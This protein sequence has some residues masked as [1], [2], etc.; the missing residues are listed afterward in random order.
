MNQ[1]ISITETALQESA[2]KKSKLQSTTTITITYIKPLT[3]FIKPLSKTTS[4]K[5]F[6]AT[7]FTKS[8][9]TS[10]PTEL[11]TIAMSILSESVISTAETT[12]IDTD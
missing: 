5:Y 6:I 10:T 7:T 9:T 8:S 11:S 1:L 4:T 3:S 12:T 2:Y